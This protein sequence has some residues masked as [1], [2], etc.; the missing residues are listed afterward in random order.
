MW[1]LIILELDN[2]VD[3][4][5]VLKS[6]KIPTL[7]YVNNPETS[8]SN[9]IIISEKNIQSSNN[10]FNRKLIKKTSN[11]EHYQN[12]DGTITAIISIGLFFYPD[13]FKKL[14]EMAIGM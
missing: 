6:S 2:Y 12:P 8:E 5:T 7:L 11:S 14:A 10:K 13:I 3:S 9:K 1:H 4:K